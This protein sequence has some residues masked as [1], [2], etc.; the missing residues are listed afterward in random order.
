M[1]ILTRDYLKK[2]GNPKYLAFAEYC[3]GRIYQAQGMNDQALPL[4]LNAKTIAED[5]D[6]NDI[7]GLIH[8]YIGQLY[9]NQR[10]YDDAAGCFKAALKYFNGSKDNYKRK[11][12]AFND[13]ANC[14][15]LKGIR[16]S[17][18]IYYNEAFNLTQTGRDSA[19]VK[20]NL[21]VMHLILNECGMAKQQL[22]QALCLKPDS[23]LRNLIYLNLGKVYEKEKVMDSAVY[24]AKLSLQFVKSNNIYVLASIYNTLSNME[25]GRGNYEKA[26]GYSSLYINCLIRINNEEQNNRNM[27]TI[28][29]KHNLDVLQHKN[30]TLTAVMRWTVT[31]TS[32]LAFVLTVCL[33]FLYLAKKKACESEKQPAELQRLLTELEKQLAD[34]KNDYEKREVTFC[35]LVQKIIKKTVLFDCYIDFASKKVDR[36]KF[37]SN[38]SEMKQLFPANELTDLYDDINT[39]YDNILYETKN[40]YPN[41]TEQEFKIICLIYAGFDNYDIALLL[42]LDKHSVE[43][44]KSEIRKKL[45]IETRGDI[46]AF[47]VKN[48]K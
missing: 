22:F 30:S 7:K 25:K 20:Q 15:L 11:M 8:S 28:E 24:F 21:G 18:M 43:R 19:S 40:K 41:L 4:Y 27:Q 31:G 32:L 39:L 37:L 10:K 17:A 42:D 12:A 29:T 36:E 3:L 16:D 26:Y 6:D 34:I 13:I 33:R 48:T 9:Y 1:I 46:K 47:I 38:M 14:F 5:S 35:R 45:K 2:T 23:T 44:S